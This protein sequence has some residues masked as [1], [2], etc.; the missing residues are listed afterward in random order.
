MACKILSVKDNQGNE[1]TLYNDLLAYTGDQQ[2]A[3][4]SYIK[5]QSKDFLDF[6]GDKEFDYTDVVE[7]MDNNYPNLIYPA[8]KAVASIKPKVTIEQQRQWYIDKF[9]NDSD[10]EIV[11]GLIAGDALGTVMENGQI[12]LSDKAEDGTLFHESFEKVFYLYLSETEQQTLRDELRDSNYKD[13][14]LYKSLK[15]VYSNDADLE[16]EYL[17]ER[18][19]DYVLDQG[20]ED[21]IPIRS[22][23]RRLLNFIKNIITPNTI[24]D[25][26][27]NIQ[28]GYYRNKLPQRLS[29]PQTF[30]KEGITDNGFSPQEAQF[31]LEGFNYYFMDSLFNITDPESLLSNQSKASDVYQDAWEEFTL[32]AVN[33][34]LDS[35]SDEEAEKY[36]ALKRN[37]K[38][39]REAHAEYLKQYGIEVKSDDVNFRVDENGSFY[40]KED[41]TKEDSL[42]RQIKDFFKFSTKD[43]MPKAVKMLLA[44]IPVIDSVDKDGT[45]IYDFNPLLTTTPRTVP[46]QELYSFLA[47]NLAGVPDWAIFDELKKL[48]SIRPEVSEI[49]NRMYMDTNNPGFSVDPEYGTDPLDFKVQSEFVQT[50]SKTDMTFM[51]Q[52]IANDGRIE[53]LNLND[54]EL[55]KRYKNDILN[56]LEQGKLG[57]ADLSNMKPNEFFELVGLDDLVKLKGNAKSQAIKAFSY[58]QTLPVRSEKEESLTS[59]IKNNGDQKGNVNTIIDVALENSKTTQELMLINAEGEKIYSITMNN[60]LSLVTDE[61]NYIISNTSS[62]DEREALIEKHLSHLLNFNTKNSRWLQAAINNKK[63]INLAI[64]DGVAQENKPGSANKDIDA[65]DKH[66]QNINAVLKGLI[67][68]TFSIPFMRA[69]DRG[70]ENMFTLDRSLFIKDTARFNEVMRGYLVDE[71]RATYELINNNVGANIWNYREKAKDLRIFKDI[72]SED[73]YTY[74]MDAISEPVE[75]DVDAYLTKLI[76]DTEALDGDFNKFVETKVGELKTELKDFGLLNNGEEIS[77]GNN[78]ADL[79]LL[80][81]EGIYKSKYSDIKANSG[82]GFKPTDIVDSLLKDYFHNYYAGMIEQTKLYT[83]DLANFKSIT[84]ISKRTSALNG[85]KL[86]MFTS[87]GFNQVM[88]DTYA[89]RLDGKSFDNTREAVM[90]VQDVEVETSKQVEDSIIAGLKKIGMSQSE[91]DNTIKSYKGANEADAQALST[92]DASREMYIRSGKWTPNHEQIYKEETELLKLLFRKLNGENVDKDIKAWRPTEFSKGEVSNIMTLKTQYYGP[93]YTKGKGYNKLYTPSMHKHSVGTMMPSTLYRV[94]SEGNVILRDRALTAYQQATNNAV[95]IIEFQSAAK[96]GIKVDENGKMQPLYNPDGT[97]AEW[98]SNLI[99]E[100]EYKY[101]GIQL[102]IS[103]KRK[104]TKTYGTQQRK[105]NFANLFESGEIQIEALSKVF[106]DHLEVQ[107]ELILRPYKEVMD[108][109]GLVANDKGEI[110]YTGKSDAFVDRLLDAATT[111]GVADNIIE[112]INSLRTVEIGNENLLDNT[113]VKEKVE[114]ILFS[115]INS[116]SIKQKVNGASMPQ[117]ASTLFEWEG[118]D[119]NTANTDLGFYRTIKDVNGNDMV[120]PMEVEIVLPESYRQY[121]ESLETDDIRGIDVLNNKIEALLTKLD[122][123]GW[124]R[125]KLTPEESTLLSMIEVQGYRIPTQD[126]SSIEAMVIKRFMPTSSGE[127]VRLPSEIVVKSGGDYDIDKLNIQMP[128]VLYDKEGN[129]RVPNNEPNFMEWFK[130]QP[131]FREMLNTSNIV[132]GLEQE[133]GIK[134][135]DVDVLKTLDEDRFNKII[136]NPNSALSTLLLNNRALKEIWSEAKANFERAPYK[137][138]ISNADYQNQLLVQKR[139]IILHPDNFGYLV[140]PVDDGKLNAKTGITK[141]IRDLRAQNKNL[142]KSKKEVTLSSLIDPIEQ[143]KLFQNFLAGKA[144][145]GQAAVHITSHAIALQLGNSQL[146]TLPEAYPFRSNEETDEEFL[147]RVPEEGKLPEDPPQLGIPFNRRRTRGNELISD[148]MSQILTG[149]VDIAKDPYIFDLNAGRQ[150]ANV[151]FMML[152]M[153]TPVD[154]IFYFVTQPEIVNY[155]KAQALNEASILE[156]KDK[157]TRKVL[158][159]NVELQLIAMGIT[160]KQTS[161]DPFESAQQLKKSELNNLVYRKETAIGAYKYWKSLPTETDSQKKKKEEARLVFEG[162]KPNME[163]NKSMLAEGIKGNPVPKVMD[164]FLLMQE[165]SKMFQ[166]YVRAN[167]PDTSTLGKNINELQKWEQDRMQVLDDGFV[168]GLNRVLKDT[169]ISP[170]TTVMETTLNGMTKANLYLM[171]SNPVLSDLFPRVQKEIAELGSGNNLQSRDAVSNEFVSFILQTYGNSEDSPV[172]DESLITSTDLVDKLDEMKQKYPFNELLKSLGA[173]RNYD[174]S[175]L[176]FIKLYRISRDIANQNAITEGWEELF[177]SEDYKFAHD[178]MRLSV[179]QTGITST[180]HSFSDFIPFNRYVDYTR[181]ILKTAMDTMAVLDDEGIKEDII[182]NFRQMFL[183]NRSNIKYVKKMNY[184]KVKE[185]ITPDNP[186][187]GAEMVAKWKAHEEGSQMMRDERGQYIYYAIDPQADENGNQ[188]ATF[189][190]MIKTDEIRGSRYHKNYAPRGNVDSK[191]SPETA[192]QLVS[193]S[194]NVDESC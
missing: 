157:K 149:Y 25:V 138:R 98:N 32:Y 90:V 35:S 62:K 127:K 178:L 120:R 186:L 112:S 75:G 13:T 30:R 147:S 45:P 130:R 23:F 2:R 4:L 5:S 154:D 67:N 26:Y 42:Q 148:V 128:N 107:K 115:M 71:L 177:S 95:G 94:D 8:S 141:E 176:N 44:N 110:I 136:S 172:Y 118:R 73:N 171:H 151:I 11:Q 63:L 29:K 15:E 17:A 131:E 61:L 50:F 156:S 146:F 133:L 175:G 69:A 65:P 3:Y 79:P 36:K 153:G 142:K 97:I 20:S 113:P 47:K 116:S 96:V 58:L 121:V 161:A 37:F 19:R 167:S 126:L 166:A 88:K 165:Y 51:K 10:L 105:L 134:I 188:T 66:A 14:P 1:S 182:N 187:Y 53:F 163:Y 56:I 34:K 60:Y 68:N 145:V 74:L 189:P 162:L 139:E 77:I 93:M 6:I 103:P 40:E 193:N 185:P 33:P 54:D 132:K 24:E 12:M 21:N 86:K 140:L 48:E 80:F 191:V 181:P 46:F 119:I 64:I 190:R 102:E 168:V 31:I 152:R 183:L 117:E 104:E 184:L 28:S 164:S 106:K 124:S 135:K 174:Q 192:A 123:S 41:D 150:V 100:L 9:G 55:R 111:R 92:L 170:F 57:D 109:I 83:G 16:V 38:G 144:G 179:M 173:L 39:L 85:T 87:D 18:F 194:E 22:I 89:P 78:K 155:V 49:M 137:E 125:K 84:D 180:P 160:P 169:I 43:N 52:I 143:V 70:V 101:L 99:Q 158:K 81:D 129:P 82:I 108:E 72:L 122:D 76:K 7:F 27:K 59:V 159:S 114:N 91:I